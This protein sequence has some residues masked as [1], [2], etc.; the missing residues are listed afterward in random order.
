MLPQFLPSLP[1]VPHAA[2]TNLD[3]YAGMPRVD[4]SNTVQEAWMRHTV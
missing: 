1:N 2:S 4:I 3:A